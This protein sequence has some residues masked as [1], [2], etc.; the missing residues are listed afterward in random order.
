[1]ELRLAYLAKS[2]KRRNAYLAILVDSHGG[3]WHINL[4]HEAPHKA[5]EET[6]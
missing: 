5:G 6:R 4:K 2:V 1:M 3:R